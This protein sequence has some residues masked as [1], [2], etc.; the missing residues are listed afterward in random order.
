MAAKSITENSDGL[1]T[2]VK[3]YDPYAS[4]DGTAVGTATGKVERE[5]VGLNGNRYAY[6]D[7]VVVVRYNY[8]GEFEVSKISSIKDD[9]NDDILF[10]RDSKVVT[11]VCI[12]EVTGT[13]T[14]TGTTPTVTDDGTAESAEINLSS[15]KIDVV[16]RDS[17]G[18]SVDALAR[19]ALTAAGFTVNGTAASGSE[20][21]YFATAANGQ[22][23]TLTTSTTTLYA[24]KLE[25]ANTDVKVTSPSTVYLKSSD[26]VT[27]QLTKQSGNLAKD[28]YTVTLSD[29]TN[30]SAGTANQDDSVLTIATF[31]LTASTNN[32]SG[33]VTISMS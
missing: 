22:P 2:S 16:D 14:P 8:K 19:E 21:I 1:V 25:Y 12:V 11:G 20:I 15:N 9:Y 4:G 13:G 18:K 32:A 28:S 6:D 10:V 24:I 7:D 27:V 3:L 33:T 17:T 30:L 29:T 26:S 31:T 5:T 23:Y